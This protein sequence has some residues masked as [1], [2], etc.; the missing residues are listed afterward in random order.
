M[1]VRRG[2]QNGHVGK[3]EFY[4]KLEIS[5]SI[6]ISSNEGLLPGMTLTMHKSQFHCS[7]YHVMVSLQFTHV[8]SFV[9]R[10][11]L[12]LPDWPFLGQIS[13]IWLRFKL[14]GLKILFGFF[15]ASFQ[16]C[17]SFL[18]N[19][20]LAILGKVPNLRA[21]CFTVVLYCVTVTWY[22]IF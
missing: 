22:K 4:R 17:L 19:F 3:P 15:L 8:C 5:S 20:H 7:G 11:R 18:W 9:C 13:E 14:V 21:I 10:G 12:E 16:H 1:G 6:P 2:S